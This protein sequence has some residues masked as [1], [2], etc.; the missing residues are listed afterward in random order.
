MSTGSPAASARTTSCW[1]PSR[2]RPASSRSGAAS[3]ARA[4]SC[5]CAASGSS[6]AASTTSRSCYILR[7]MRRSLV[8]V[9]LVLAAAAVALAARDGGHGQRQPSIATAIRLC[10]DV[11]SQQMRDHCY[12]RE[13]L[14]V[15]DAAGDPAHEVPRIGAF[16]Q[17][18]GGYL[19]EAC[20]M[21]MHGVGRAYGQEHHVRL[22]Q[23]Q[24]MLPRSNDPSC[25][26]GFAHGLIIA[27]GP[28]VLKAG[29]QG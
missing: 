6:C 18:N 22:A 23:L 21:L 4:S 25:S 5:A 20:H 12:V 26:A 16:A 3:R 10:E 15:L 1:P 14:G 13:L 19:A 2:T 29:P 11:A 27:L 17:R 7:A 24:E 8:P 9:L 28:E